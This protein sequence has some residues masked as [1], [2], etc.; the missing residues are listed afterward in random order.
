MLF[1]LETGEAHTD[2]L[3]WVEEP[4]NA[5]VFLFDPLNQ[6]IDVSELE[7]G[8]NDQVAAKGEKSGAEERQWN[9]QMQDAK[10]IVVFGSRDQNAEY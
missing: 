3:G 7:Y 1:Y 9:K 4:G 6:A 8:M 10:R 2:L 5:A